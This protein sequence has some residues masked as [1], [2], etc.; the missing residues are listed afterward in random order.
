MK[1]STPHKLV[2]CSQ[3]IRW[4]GH[5]ALARVAGGGGEPVVVNGFIM[6]DTI[7]IR[8]GG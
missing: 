2:L 4:L 7:I 6:K 8:T 3:T 5:E 1:R